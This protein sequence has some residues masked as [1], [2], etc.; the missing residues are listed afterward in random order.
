[1][2]GIAVDEQVP[3]QES[4]ACVIDFDRTTLARSDRR[5]MMQE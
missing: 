4:R 5:I 2:K 1:V 3:D